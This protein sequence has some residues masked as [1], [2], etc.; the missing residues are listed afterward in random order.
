MVPNRHPRCERTAGKVPRPGVHLRPH[1][2]P[3]GGS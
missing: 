2:G 1:T 3:D